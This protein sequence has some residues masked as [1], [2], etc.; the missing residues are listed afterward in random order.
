MVQEIWAVP[1]D[2]LEHERRQ[3]RS[4]RPAGSTPACGSEVSVSGPVFCGLAEAKPFRS[5]PQRS[6]CTLLSRI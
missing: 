3:F 4:L 1:I 6:V 2:F 5:L